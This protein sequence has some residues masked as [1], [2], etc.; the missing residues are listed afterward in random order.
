M[1]KAGGDVVLLSSVLHALLKSVSGSKP[2]LKAG[3]R[4]LATGSGAV[5]L[6]P[7]EIRK[8]LT[9]EYFR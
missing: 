8:I 3:I 2:Q 1:E 7:R 6:E 9:N 4:V 5:Y